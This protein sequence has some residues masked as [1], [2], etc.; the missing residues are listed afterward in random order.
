MSRRQHSPVITPAAVAAVAAMEQLD[1]VTAATRAPF[2]HRVA[3]LR[4]LSES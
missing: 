1:S 4:D 2:S 3:F